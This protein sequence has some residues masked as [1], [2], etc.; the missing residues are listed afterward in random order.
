[1]KTLMKVVSVIF[2]IMMVAAIVPIITTDMSRDLLLF[3]SKTQMIFAQNI[4]PIITICLCCYCLER[5]DNNYLLRIIPI[6]M[7]IS[8]ILSM[9]LYYFSY[10][11]YAAYLSN[12][13][14]AKGLD[15]N[16]FSVM[17]IEVSNF[18]S[19]THIYIAL[20]SLLLIIKPNNQ[21]TDIIKKITYG[22]IIV[23]LAL[24]IWIQ[25][26]SYMEETLPNVYDYEGYDGSGFNFTSISDTKDFANTV[27]Q[28][29][30]VGEIFAVILLFTT[31]YAFSITIDYSEDDIDIYETKKEA[32]NLANEQMKQKYTTKPIEE[33]KQ[34]DRTSSEK[35]LMNINNQL[36][37]DSNVGKVKESAKE[38][39][40]Q[41]S[42]MDE[43]MPLSN[44][45]V[46]N[47]TVNRKPLP[48]MV[49]PANEFGNNQNITE[50]N[51]NIPIE[52]NSNIQQQQNAPIETN[53][54]IQQIPQN[55]PTDIN[56]NN[57][58]N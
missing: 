34:I 15:I 30:T 20:I 29:S 24:N 44:G 7:L 52:N 51:Q 48:N 28:I 42:T 12:G 27:Y 35:G 11:D 56:Q 53:Q 55:I 31:N 54:N 8:I 41:E 49:N 9:F 23:N 50:Q 14:S 2:L 10:T 37:I 17:I 58:Q 57:N 1:M 18:L 25:V 47:E 45:P 43:L 19:K 5:N 38:T 16:G 21:I 22:I 33:P 4:I 3:F 40:V 26:K 36:G 6:F 13:S 39:N 46:I 32:E